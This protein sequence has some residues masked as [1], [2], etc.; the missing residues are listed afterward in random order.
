MQEAMH[1][2]KE[3]ALREWARRTEVELYGYRRRAAKRKARKQ[4]R[5][6][7]RRERRGE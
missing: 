4:R 5:K 3:E 7:A 6:A 2:D 1:R